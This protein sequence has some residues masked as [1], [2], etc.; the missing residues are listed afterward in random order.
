LAPLRLRI[1]LL[2]AMLVLAVV[3][4][5]AY[6][7]PPP[8]DDYLAA[9]RI[10]QPG[11]LLQDEF[12]DLTKNTDEATVEAD[13][14]G[15]GG[16]AG[17]EIT[18]CDFANGRQVHYGKTVWYDFFPDVDGVVLIQAAGFD[19]VIGMVPYN[20]SN[21]RPFFDEWVCADHPT[22]AASE[23]A[24]FDV[25]EGRS[26]SI[27][28]GGYAGE[29]P[30]P[31]V[32]KSGDLEF[33]FT[34]FPDTDGDGVLDQDD[35]CVD[36][37][38]KASLQGCPDDDNDDIRNSQDRCPTQ[39]GPLNFGGCPD[40]DG[41]GKPDPDDACPAVQGDLANGCPSPPPPPDADGDGVLDNGA[42]KC[43]GENSR[44]R[45][46]NNNGCLDL[47]T[48]SPT[49][50]FKPGSYFDRR[51]GR[52]V[53]LGLSVKRFGVSGAP[54]GARVVVTCT[55][56]ECRRMAK[57]ANSRALFGRLRGEEL[58]AGVRVTIRVTAPGYVGRARVYTIK[59]NDFSA[60][61]R[62]LLP[63]SPRLRA[64]CS[65]VR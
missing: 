46:E 20:F 65:P 55:Q 50:I 53:L 61:N 44:P 1:V 3:P 35:Q 14:F 37:P 58:P 39:A 22:Q 40:S 60:T 9:Q 56:R 19:A 17:P 33:G 6:A 2:A 34:F 28:I 12:E 38:G 18:R 51:G 21:A 48:F 43:L 45:D 42:D 47:R 31:L 59:K 30:T 62:C 52:I 64:S 8:N 16:D 23:S 32:P 63:G 25:S 54:R 7:A 10:N 26:Y 36:Q 15:P 29:G 27:Q 57:R 5:S 4:A 49:W 24:V 11:S 13:L 41:D